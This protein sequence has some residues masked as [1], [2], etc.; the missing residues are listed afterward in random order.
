MAAPD[1]KNAHIRRGGS[2][3]ESMEVKADEAKRLLDDPAFQ[4]AYDAVR[5]GLVNALAE[6]RHDGQPETDAFE[7]ELCRSLRTLS[8]MRR[9]IALAV[10]KH[11]L[12]LVDFQR[13]GDNEGE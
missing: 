3:R 5:E 13:L 6:L 8:S 9:A 1:P 11:K 12:S 10:Q 4:R 7:R 2:K